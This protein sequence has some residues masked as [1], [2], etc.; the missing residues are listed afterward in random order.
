MCNTRIIKMQ[1]VNNKFGYYMME[2]EIIVN[3]RL[4]PRTMGGKIRQAREVKEWTQPFLAQV[5]EIDQAVI[6][7]YENDKIK[8]INMP[9]LERIADKL[10]ITTAY[11]LEKEP[12]LPH[13]D[14]ELIDFVKDPD[15]VWYIRKAF[16]DAET[17]R[18]NKEKC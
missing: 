9:D 10:N 14:D 13:L 1:I 8:R 17:E 12:E 3:K 11:L 5:T 18:H 2:R 4:V 7:R 15:N 6:S 16:L